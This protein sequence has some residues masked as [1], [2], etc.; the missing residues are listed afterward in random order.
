MKSTYKI[1]LGL[2]VGGIISYLLGPSIQTFGTEFTPE[3]PKQT[4]Y[5]YTNQ[6]YNTVNYQT[7]DR[8]IKRFMAQWELTGASLAISKNG[9]QIY[10]KGYGWADKE[11]QIEAEP[12]HLFRIAS[13][14]KLITAIG[15][16]KLVD[17]EKLKL[18]DKAFGPNGI[19]NKEPYL[20]YIDNRVEE[21][22]VE[23][24]L[25]HT[26]GW[27]TH[28]GD[29]LFIPH[30]ISSQTKKELP[31]SQE[32]IIEFMLQKRLHFKPGTDSYYS[33]LGYVILEKIIETITEENYEEYIKSEILYPLE[34]Y[35]MTIGRSFEHEKLQLE[36]KYY[37][38]I[39]S[40]PKLQFNSF[41]LYNRESYG[42]NDIQTLGGAGGWVASSTDLLKLL[43]ALDYENS[44]QLILSKNSLLKMTQMSPEGF[45]P[46]GWREITTNT[47]YRTGTLAG[48]SAIMTRLNN[49]Y[50]F[51]L[52]FNSSTWK[53][54]AL[55]TY[56]LK[57][58]NTTIRQLERNEFAKS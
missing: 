29:P 30:S 34:I 16:M 20:S 9:E 58:F 50:S 22:T 54:S 18:E 6:C 56:V 43:N 14:S 41:N 1:I 12:Y 42:G 17:Q 49:G 2:I 27:T 46:I 5:Y 10:T 35:D 47:W 4:S 40:E 52:I 53:G 48:T 55:S 57:M 38:P 21:I 15:V 51:V 11:N 28:W 23:Q 26:A 7:V 24:L 33:N 19:L 45:Q 3:I 13:I 8:N 32:D 36:V 31:L 37:E 44:D 25:T 39:D